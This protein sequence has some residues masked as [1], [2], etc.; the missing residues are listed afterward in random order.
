MSS[1]L[2]PSETHW[3]RTSSLVVR[4]QA[5]R[6][7]WKPARPSTDHIEKN[8]TTA[9]SRVHNCRQGNQSANVI[10]QHQYRGNVIKIFLDCINS[11]IASFALTQFIIK[12]FTYCSGV[13]IQHTIWYC[14]EASWEILKV[15]HTYF[16][17]EVINVN[18]LRSQMSHVYMPTFLV[19]FYNTLPNYFPES[20]V[21]FT[22]STCS[23]FSGVS[24][25]ILCTYFAYNFHVFSL[26]GS[27]F[28]YFSVHVLS[29]ISGTSVHVFHIQYVY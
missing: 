24:E 7:V 4:L 8:A 17:L 26:Q 20:D 27:A 25:V 14:W 19:E 12:T 5:A 10:M 22:R 28:R 21:Q 2:Q 1:H 18:Y 3:L 29:G 16:K 15:Y 23:D 13:M 11:L 9:T 6:N